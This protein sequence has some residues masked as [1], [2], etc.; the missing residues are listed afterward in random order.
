MFSEILAYLQDEICGRILKIM[1]FT[2]SL[3]FYKGAELC[4]SEREESLWGC[5]QALFIMKANTI[6][7]DT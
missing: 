7:A 1:N 6:E 4:N 3:A 5:P 2:R